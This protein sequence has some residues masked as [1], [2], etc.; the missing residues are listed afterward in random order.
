MEADFSG[1]A[2]KAGLKCSDGRTITPNAFKHMDGKKVPLVWQHGHGDPKNVLGHAILEARED[3]MYS[4]GYFNETTTGKNSKMMVQHGDVTSLSIYANKLVEKGSQV[5]HGEIREVSLVLSGANPGALIDYV[6]IA[7]ADGDVETLEDEAIIYTGLTLEHEDKQEE[8]AHAADSTVQEVYDSLTD[9]QKELVHFMVGAA[10]ES[11]GGT[12]QQSDIPDDVQE[13][14]EEKALTHQEGADMTRNVFEQNEDTKPER[15]TLTHDQMKSIL[16]DAKRTGSLKESFLAHAVEYGIE[17]IDFLFPDARAIANSPEFVSRKMEWVSGVINGAR[18]TPFSRIKSLSADIT[19]DEA[20]AKGYIKGTLKKEEFF[21]LAKRETGPKTIY[22]KQKLDRDDI[23]DITDLDVVAW[24]KA[25]M[26]VMLEEEIARAILLGDGRDVSDED[27]IDEDKIRPIA[28]D[29]NFYAHKVLLA[30]GVAGDDLVDQILLA[31]PNYLGN[32]N[33]TMYTT[34]T[35][36]TQLILIKDDLGRRIYGTQAELESA[37]RVSKIVPVPVMEG[38]TIGAD[39]LVAILVNM[40]DYT[41]GAD[42]G[43]A[44]SLFDDFD[45][46]YNQYK[47]L[48]E[49]RISGALTKHKTAL[50]FVQDTTP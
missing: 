30:N 10:L 22:K 5:L 27:K 28:K 40:S 13:I 47:Y 37:L 7:H 4:Y 17:N 25:E 1:Y 38:E 12:A 11:A 24:L 44:I 23:I 16:T 19:H 29:D 34:E 42:K 33:P 14:T 49:T 50:V 8:V 36:L 26:R 46:D 43:G 6:S 35:L 15:K 18:H 21:A 3:G 45:I 39:A 41:I 20:R 48:I 32:G 31:R 9:E 2:T